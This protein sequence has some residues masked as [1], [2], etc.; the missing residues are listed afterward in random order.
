[1]RVLRPS[2]IA[3]VLLASIAALACFASPADASGPRTGYVTSVGGASVTPFDAYSGV[4]G[5]PIALSGNNSWGVAVTPDGA[6]AYVADES[7]NSVVPI[8]TATGLA[9]APIAVG[10]APRMLAITPDGAKVYVANIF[11]NSVTPIDTATNTAGRAI[12]VGTSPHGVAIA[13]D[14]SRAYVTNFNSGSVSVID[15]ATDTVVDTIAVGARPYTIAITPDGATVYVTNIGFNTVTAIDT[16]TAT[17]DT[18]INVGTSTFGVAVA[19]DGRTAYVSAS[20]ISALVPIDTAT[21]TPGTPLPIGS[22][23]EGIAI[24]PDGGTAWVTDVG[25]DS[26]MPLDLSDGSVGAARAVGHSPIG[27]AITPDQAPAAAFATSMSDLTASLDAAAS[28]DPDGTIAR[29]AWDFGDGQ[30][31]TGA[32]PTLSHS[33]AQPGT[34]SVTLT[35]TDDEGCSDALV[36]TGQTAACADAPTAHVTHTVTVAAPAPPASPGSPSP[37]G[38]PLGRQAI[39]RF[40]LAHR[41]VRPGRDGTAHIGL[42]LRLALAGSVALRVDRAAIDVNA[43]RCPARDPKRHYDGKLRRVAA[44]EHVATQAATA[45]VRRSLSAGFD[46]RPGLYRISVRAYGPDGALT[47]PAYRWVRVLAGR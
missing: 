25:S 16:A 31:A 6:T 40:T 10:N 4:F 19:P 38:S 32:T 14:G 33:Y 35:V 47:R 22:S 12:P 24:T 45:S 23:P 20:G 44:R 39:E 13:P 46:L 8:D 43:E 26:V 5:T 42:R 15:V 11:S 36:F 7:S 34:Y 21:N 3:P 29:Y 37:T 9:G 18:P 1:M 41:C 30:S 2:F 17:A 28:S 27:I